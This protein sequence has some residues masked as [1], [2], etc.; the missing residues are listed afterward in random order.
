M[1]HGGVMVSGAAARP[2]AAP[3]SAPMPM[4][5]RSTMSAT[6]KGELGQLSSNL[7]TRHWPRSAIGG[8]RWGPRDESVNANDELCET[9]RHLSLHGQRDTND[10]FPSARMTPR[11]YATR[12]RA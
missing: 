6:S 12:T 1:A 2:T 10:A 4:Y 9:T 7:A 3:P 8:W 11:C 5:A